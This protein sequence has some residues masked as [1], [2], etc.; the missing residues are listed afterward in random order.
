M[1]RVG[2]RRQ[3]DILIVG[4]PRRPLSSRR[5]GKGLQLGRAERLRVRSPVIYTAPVPTPLLAPLPERA[6]PASVVRSCRRHEPQPR[7]RILPA[8]SDGSITPRSRKERGHRNLAP[9]RGDKFARSGCGRRVRSC[10]GFRM[11][12]TRTSPRAPR[13]AFESRHNRRR[14]EI[15][16]R[17][18][19]FAQARA[20]LRLP[21]FPLHRQRTSQAARSAMCGPSLLGRWTQRRVVM[22]NEPIVPLLH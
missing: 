17:D 8:C 2:R 20:A 1:V 21:H 6:I 16:S 5:F 22:R 3:P 13:P 18:G 14:T 11:P 10:D 7:R 15:I 9:G 4:H 12:A 19:L